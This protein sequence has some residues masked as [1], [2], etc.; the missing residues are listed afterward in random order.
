MGR[1]FRR[2][3]SHVF[4]ILGVAFF[5]LSHLLLIFQGPPSTSLVSLDSRVYYFF[6]LKVAEP[7]RMTPPLTQSHSHVAF[8]DGTV[9]A[10][11]PRNPPKQTKELSTQGVAIVITV[12]GA[13]DY[14][15]SCLESWNLHT[16]NSGVFLADDCETKE[17]SKELETLASSYENVTVVVATT[18]IGSVG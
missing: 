1:T 5:F 11:A 4:Y 17:E 10:L 6:S 16:T 15:A 12:H 8:I 9:D 7:F 13:L 14:L 2:R 3:G 18:G